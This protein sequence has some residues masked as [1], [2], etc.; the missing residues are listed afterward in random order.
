L[1]VLATAPPAAA[2]LTFLLQLACPLYVTGKRSGFCNYQDQDLL[3]GWVG[4]VVVAFLVDAV[5]VAGLFFASAQQALAMQSADPAT[6]H[7][8][9]RCP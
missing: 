7:E 1:F 8:Q 3:G 9:P 5:F 6:I 4:G 2:A